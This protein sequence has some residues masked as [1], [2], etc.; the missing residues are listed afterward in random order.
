MLKDAMSR[1]L[2]ALLVAWTLV[3]GIRR[4]KLRGRRPACRN[5]GTDSGLPAQREALIA[6]R[7]DVGADRAIMRHAA[8]IGHE[9]ARLS[10]HVRAEIPG[11]F[12]L[13]QQGGV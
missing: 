7:R 9:D 13:G 4:L 10:G 1:S 8:G 2:H 5:D 3:P 11:M 12:R 6:A